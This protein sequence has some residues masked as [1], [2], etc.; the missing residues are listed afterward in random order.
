MVDLAIILIFTWFILSF[1]KI[2]MKL[3]GLKRQ[4]K[5]KQNLSSTN[6]VELLQTAL[7]L[8]QFFH[9]L[10]KIRILLFLVEYRRIMLSK[11]IESEIHF[12]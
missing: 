1:S 8:I 9:F 3:S 2:Q 6:Q 11:G 10:N 12:S 5:Y 4:T 7:L